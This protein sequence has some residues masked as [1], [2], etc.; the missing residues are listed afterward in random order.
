M[1]PE[2]KRFSELANDV[3]VAKHR[4]MTRKKM[5]MFVDARCLIPLFIGLAGRQFV[6]GLSGGATVSE[7]ETTLS[8]LRLSVLHLQFCHGATLEAG[9]NDEMPADQ[10]KQAHH[11]QHDRE[12]L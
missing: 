3:L 9:I 2:L 1:C 12:R 8:L 11:C 7:R 10:I 5:F 4:K 6:K